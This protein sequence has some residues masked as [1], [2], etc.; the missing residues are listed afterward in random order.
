ML[1]KRITQG[2]K[3]PW[4]IQCD[5]MFDSI[6]KLLETY[7]GIILEIISGKEEQLAHINVYSSF[8]LSV[9]KVEMNLNMAFVHVHGHAFMYYSLE[10][11]QSRAKAILLSFFLSKMS[12][13]FQH[14]ILA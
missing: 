13:F 5:P 4:F 1:P 3:R 9:R 8:I 10:S 12:F 14:S 11:T 2:T 7:F 6:S